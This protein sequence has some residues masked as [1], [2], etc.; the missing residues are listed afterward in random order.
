MSTNAALLRT[1]SA[2]IP[3]KRADPRACVNMPATLRAAGANGFSIRVFNLSLNGF[4][5]EAVTGM[6]EGSR[7]WITFPGLNSLE[8]RVIWNDGIRVGC[9]LIQLLAT[10]VFDRLVARFETAD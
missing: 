8:A 2:Y 10:P 7:C 9:E 1:G 5:C 3:E 6:R 4:S